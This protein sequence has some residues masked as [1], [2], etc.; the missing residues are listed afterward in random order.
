MNSGRKRLRVIAGLK[1]RIK[2]LQETHN[3]KVKSQTG[4]LNTIEILTQQ[5]SDVTD[6]NRKIQHQIDEM[7]KQL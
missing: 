4:L 7:M 1:E 6:E 2:E 5:V 3:Q